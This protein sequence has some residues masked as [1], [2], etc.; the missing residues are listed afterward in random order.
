MHS[1]L[2]EDRNMLQIHCKAQPPPRIKEDTGVNHLPKVHDC[3][4]NVSGDDAQGA[5][6]FGGRDKGFAL[7]KSVPNGASGHRCFQVVY[8]VSERVEAENS[9]RERERWAGVWRERLRHLFFHVFILLILLCFFIC[10]CG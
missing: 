8:D 3:V 9:V 6:G 2:I 10:L 1:G 7:E 4:A 5:D